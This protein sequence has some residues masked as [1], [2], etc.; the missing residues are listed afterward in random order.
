MTRQ[1]IGGPLQICEISEIV[2]ATS[3][4]RLC[5]FCALTIIGHTTR[6]IYYSNITLAGI[7]QFDMLLLTAYYAKYA[8][9]FFYCFI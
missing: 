6:F 8:L 4:A 7:L 5:K 9:H 1:N 2:T 3:A